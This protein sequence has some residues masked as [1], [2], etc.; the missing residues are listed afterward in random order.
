[1]VNKLLSSTCYQLSRFQ[2]LRTKFPIS[3]SRTTEEKQLKHPSGEETLSVW[4]EG[5]AGGERVCVGVPGGCGS[6]EEAM[7]QPLGKLE[8]HEDVDEDL[9]SWC[10]A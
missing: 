10:L 2:V 3:C 1:M 9:D 7:V 8:F 4:E 5:V 6:G